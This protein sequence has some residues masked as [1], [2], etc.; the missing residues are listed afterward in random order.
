MNKLIKLGASV[1]FQSVAPIIIFALLG[2]ILGDNRYANGF[3]ITYPFQF[4]MSLLFMI[5]FK[6]QLKSCI[7]NKDESFSQ[8]YGGLCMLVFAYTLLISFAY[9]FSEEILRLLGF[10]VWYVFLFR[11]SLLIMALD[12]IF[13]A[14]VFIFQ[15]KGKNNKAVA[16]SVVYCAGK[17]SVVMLCGVLSLKGWIVFFSVSVYAAL[18]VI[19]SIVSNFRIRGIK[20]S[21]L[22]GIKYSVYNLPSD[23]CMFFVYVFGI[24]SMSSNS[25]MVAESYNLMS[26]CSD[27]QWDMLGDSIDTY[28]TLAVSEDRFKGVF[29]PCVLYSVLLFMTSLIM[30]GL[31]WLLPVYRSKVDFSMTL[32]MFLIECISFPIYAI[33]YLCVSYMTM[34]HPSV[35][36]FV[37]TVLAYVARFTVMMSIKSDYNVALGVLGS[38][39][40]GNTFNILLYIYYRRRDKVA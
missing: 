6:S 28:G 13:Y 36:G 1:C 34:K 40:V 18:V 5:C 19:I 4:V 39:F 7:N 9:M 16:Y 20:Y 27:T 21:L 2:V 33:R 11:F 30:I 32:V 24:N 23:V 3:M 38:S 12:W 35:Y 31:M 26:M 15:Y 29:K 17:V 8:A 14:A 25:I 37:I 10:D 22:D